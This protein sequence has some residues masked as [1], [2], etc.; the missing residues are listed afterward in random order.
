MFIL[1]F[2]FAKKYPNEFEFSHFDLV[3]TNDFFTTLNANSVINIRN[4]KFL[5]T[6]QAITRIEEHLSEFQNKYPGSSFF[7]NLFFFTVQHLE[8]L[9]H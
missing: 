6:K 7:L 9:I 5:F 1:F 4:N 2:E 3:P 8:L